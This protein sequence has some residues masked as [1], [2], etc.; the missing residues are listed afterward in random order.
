MELLKEFIQDLSKVN[1]ETVQFKDWQ[2][3]FEKDFHLDSRKDTITNKSN[4]EIK[5][6]CSKRT[7]YSISFIKW[8]FNGDNSKANNNISSSIVSIAKSI[9]G[10]TTLDLS[11][12]DISYEEMNNICNQLSDLVGKTSTLIYILLQKIFLNNATIYWF[13]VL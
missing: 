5:D 7:L 9:N 1:L 10:L 11:Y 12:W 13:K 6:S 2:F 3:S 4:E 8:K